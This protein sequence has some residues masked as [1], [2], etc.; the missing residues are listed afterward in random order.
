MVGVKHR[1]VQLRKEL[2]TSIRDASQYHAAVSSLA[3]AGYQCALLQTI[4]KPC[5]IRVPR[6]HTTGDLATGKSLGSS[7]QNTQDIVLGWRNL[8]RKSTRLNSSHV[9]ISYAVFCLKKKK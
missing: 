5:N 1:G 8:D 7:A 2:Q 6:D 3:T 9:E 4:Q